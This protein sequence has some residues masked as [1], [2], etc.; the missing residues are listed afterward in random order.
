MSSA[1]K[2]TAMST[3]STWAGV[4]PRPGT[5]TK[6]SSRSARSSAPS[7]QIACPP[8]AMPV[9]T[10]SA[11]HAARPAA[12]AASAAVPPSSS[13]SSPAAAVAGCPAA[14]PAEIGTLL[15]YGDGSDQGS[16]AG[17][18]R[19]ARS[20]RG[21]HGLLAGA[22]RAALAPNRRAHGALADAQ[23]GSPL[24]ARAAQAR[25]PAPPAPR[26]SPAQRPGGLSQLDQG[27]R[28]AT[29]GGPGR[30][31]WKFEGAPSRVCL[32]PPPP[33]SAEAKEA[34]T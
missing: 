21:R 11:T 7:Y 15:A 4:S 13:I 14:I 16:Q 22:D 3:S 23:E 10:V 32:K 26:L 31:R 6:K 28:P 12:T 17:N 34:G 33:P 19:K 9:V 29:I 1:P 8:P 18:S 2:G 5:A 27:T 30:R 24:P 20:R 25:R